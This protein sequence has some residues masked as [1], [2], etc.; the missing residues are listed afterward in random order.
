ML[1]SVFSC[2][3]SCFNG[4]KR[5][6][7]LHHYRDC[8]GKWIHYDN[9]KRRNSWGKPI[10][11]STSSAKPNIHGSKLLLCIWWDQ[12]GAVYYELLKLNESIMGGHY[13]LQLMRLSRALKEKW[14]LYE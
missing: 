11:S 7:F 8:D 5:K 12:L 1:N 9:P 2:V 6:V 13:Q 4:R 14:M 3:N 10:H